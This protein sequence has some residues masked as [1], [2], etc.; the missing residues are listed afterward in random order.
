ME[1]LRL[2]DNVERWLIHE[3]YKFTEVKNEENH[4][5][6]TIRH[7]GSF[8]NQIEVFS[9]KQQNSVLVI[10]SLVPLKNNQNARYLKLNDT[11]KE[12]FAKKVDDYCYSLRAINRMRTE[13]GKLIVGAYAVLDNE[14]KFNQQDFTETLI[15]VAEMGDKVTQFLLKTF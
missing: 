2:R 10:G 1:P 8:G 5:T 4:F 15:Q 13:D 14:E 9:P 3:N 11:Q 6:I 12:N 7:T